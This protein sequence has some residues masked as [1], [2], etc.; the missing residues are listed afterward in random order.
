[1][2]ALIGP[3]HT[4]K[5][6]PDGRLAAFLHDAPTSRA[7][8]WQDVRGQHTVVS[9]VRHFNTTQQAKKPFPPPPRPS[10][11]PRTSN[12]APVL[13]V[14]FGASALAFVGSSLIPHREMDVQESPIDDSGNLEHVDGS[15]CLQCRFAEHVLT[16][17]QMDER[18]DYQK[19]QNITGMHQPNGSS[20]TPASTTSPTSSNSI[21]VEK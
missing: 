3:L 18:S 2:R 10:A 19:S 11:T 17:Q 7:K 9:G 15:F 13:G 20:E 8:R 14:L 12:A 6:R 4:T 21:L 1:M 16:L 5:P